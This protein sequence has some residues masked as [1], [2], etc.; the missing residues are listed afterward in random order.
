M[1]CVVSLSGGRDSATC[2]GLAVDKFGTENVYAIGFEYGSTHPQELI[3]AQKIADYYLDLFELSEKKN[4]LAKELSKGMK[5]KLSMLLALMIKPQALLVDE[6]MVGL[7]PAS[8]ETVLEIFKTLKEQGCAILIST[9]IIDIINDIYDEAYIM[10]KG[11]IINHVC[12]EN[13]HDETLKEYFFE[14]TDG[15][16][17]E[18]VN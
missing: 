6:P 15:K 5:Q 2:L 9:H 11:K 17:D 18:T 14:A 3:C 4:R 7:D 10:D 12:K 8:I 1:K 13:L 16:Q